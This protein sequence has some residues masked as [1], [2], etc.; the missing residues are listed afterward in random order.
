MKVLHLAQGRKYDVWAMCDDDENCPVLETLT[1]ARLEHPDLV[2]TITALLLEEVPNGG[3][4]LHDPRRAKRLYRDLLYELKADK[5]ISRRGHVGLRIVFFFDGFL[6]GEVV[7]CTNAFH[8]TGSSTPEADLE[9]ALR[10][11][12]RYFAEKGELEF[13][14]WR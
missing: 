14:G 10:E 5:D 11:R 1:A 7:V 2:E 6:D 13:V 9:R 12:A 8:K 3:P 4:P